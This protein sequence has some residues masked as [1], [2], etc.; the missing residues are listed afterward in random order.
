MQQLENAQTLF[1]KQLKTYKDDNSYLKKF[2]FLRNKKLREFFNL[3]ELNCKNCN[4]CCCTGCY[5]NFGYFNYDE[6][7]LFKNNLRTVANRFKEKTGFLTEK[8]CSLPILLRSKTCIFHLREICVRKEFL[9]FQ[10]MFYEIVG[11]FYS[12][13]T[14]RKGLVILENL[15]EILKEFKKVKA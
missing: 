2:I 15:I 9:I 14:N 3:L 1:L 7:H 10:K 11:L 12:E 8:G 13:T 6:K 4:S 5:S